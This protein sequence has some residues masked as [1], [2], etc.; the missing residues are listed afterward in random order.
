[1]FQKNLQDMIKGIRSAAADAPT[2]IMKAVQEIKEELKSRDVTVKA[3]ALLKLVYLNMLGQDMN[4]AAF[5]IIEVM[6]QERF[7]LKR[8]GFLAASQSFSASTDVIVLS[9]QLLKKEMQARSP[10]EIGMA[11]NTLSNIA[12]PDLARDLLP[13]VMTMLSSARPYVRKKATLV[14]YKLFLQHPEGLR[15]AF[16]HI[17]RKL[18][19][20]HPS[21][22]CC[23][24]NVICELARIK[25]SNYLILVPELF[26]LL[27][28]STNNWMTIK[29]AKL[30]SSLVQVE[31]RLAR[32]LLE[33]LANI[34][35]TT[36]AKSLMYEAIS[37]ITH[38]LQYTKR[39]DGTDARNVP[40]VVR[41]CTDRL[42]ELVRE[43]DQ[44]LKYLG[45]VGLVDLMKSHPRVVA[46]HRELVLTCLMDEDVTIR[47]RALE[48]LTGMVTRRNLQDIIESLMG[49]L[50]GAEGLYREELIEKIIFMCSRDKFAYLNDF[51]W[52]IDILAKLAYIPNTTHSAT[53]AN[54]LLDVTVRVQEVRNVAMAK[55]LPMLAD[56]S[57]FN[58]IKSY[59][60]LTKPI[61]ST[62]SAS[63]AQNS[64]GPGAILHAAAWIVGE[65][66]SIIPENMHQIVVDALLQPAVLILPPAI[67]A[68]YVQAALKIT[69]RAASMASKSK[70]GNMSNFF[71][72]A[73][74]VCERLQPF[75]VSPHVEV[76]ERACLTRELLKTLGIKFQASEPTAPQRNLEED[77]MA[78]SGLPNESP[79][80]PGTPLSTDTLPP[81]DAD[82]RT[83][84][85][86][87][88]SLFEEELRPVNP[89]AQRRVPVPKGLDLDSW[90]NPA[91]AKQKEDKKESLMYTYISFEDSYGVADDDYAGGRGGSASVY[92]DDSDD[93]DDD[94][95]MEKMR[96]KG[97]KRDIALW[98]DGLPKKKKGKGR[99]GK[100]AANDPFMLRKSQEDS[101][102]EFDEYDSVPI[103]RLD[104]GDLGSKTGTLDVSI[105]GD[106]GKSKKKSK[107]SRKSK[108]GYDSDD[109]PAGRTTYRILSDEEDIPGDASDEDESD[110]DKPT[111]RLAN[112]L[113]NIDLSDPLAGEE[114]VVAPAKS[115]R[116]GRSRILG[117]DDVDEP[118][119]DKRKKRKK[120]RS[121]D[122]DEKKE[123][124]GKRREKKERKEKK[125]G[126]R[127]KEEH[128]EDTPKKK[129]K[130]ATITEGN[131]LAAA[132]PFFHTIVDDKTIHIKYATYVQPLGTAEIGTATVL[133]KLEPKSSKRSIEDISLHLPEGVTTKAGDS[134]VLL[135]SRVLPKSREN[136][137]YCEEASFEME[138]QDLSGVNPLPFIGSIEYSVKGDANTI[139]A[140]VILSAASQIIPTVIDQEE[141]R[142]M[143][144][145]KGASFNGATGSVPAITRSSGKPDVTRTLNAICG[146]F[147]AYPVAQ[148]PAHVILYGRTLSKADVTAFVKY[149]GTSTFQ[150]TIKSTLDTHADVLLAEVQAIIN[151]V[152]AANKKAK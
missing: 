129:E 146:I 151:N 45:L 113:A 3:T 78:L 94:K 61:G 62:D 8:I 33:P 64:L 17:K 15:L 98:G 147:R 108:S 111:N 90:I 23:A 144:T 99:R 44:N 76:Q 105:F 101:D 115:S 73:T 20:D 148:S 7:G 9:T 81:M 118:A 117:E 79:V 104:I 97:R 63:D 95:W 145:T 122:A 112:A 69:A 29:I 2:Y 125:E 10:Y 55:L 128:V 51:A 4:W 143:M 82:I 89:R 13:D 127:K 137:G 1:M 114:E 109:K 91:E 83:I 26:D 130:K 77:L 57:L 59:S 74:S 116:K 11:V 21:V 60:S 52:Y 40:A 42:R 136:K 121:K 58:N 65:Y 25:P 72:L 39:A 5:H 68:V 96:R 22:V 124:K 35:Q 110:D 24:V 80:A 132:E 6:S 134:K 84:A 14:L 152:I 37:T 149:D 75:V 102:D 67:Q 32:K 126:K 87:L 28:K 16:D 53:I 141:Y 38:A 48:L 140:P 70:S 30:M 18:S 103:K 139:N 120:K 100:K 49:H 27:T 93:D 56:T 123:K 92:T 86:V 36:P 31:P 54:Q 107:K 138:V 19:D 47:L 41:L 34:V 135:S 66:A 71:D 150:I 43:P 85:A 50:D 88:A 119:K 12:T 131:A 106:F 46:E 142:E 133:F